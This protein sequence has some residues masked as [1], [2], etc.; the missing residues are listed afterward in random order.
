MLVGFGVWV[1][2]VSNLLGPGAVVPRFVWGNRISD[3]IEAGRVWWLGGGCLKLI[4]SGRSRAT[5]CAEGGSFRASL[6]RSGSL[7]VG[8]G[9]WLVGV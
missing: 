1:I 4:W 9:V 2:G 3:Y 7:P 6:S 8:F 5:D